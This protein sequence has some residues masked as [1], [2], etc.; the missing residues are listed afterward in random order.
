MQ[1]IRAI[2]LK[3]SF[4]KFVF[5]VKNYICNLRKI[6]KIKNSKNK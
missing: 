5:F 4:K 2:S 3:N 6:L 1:F